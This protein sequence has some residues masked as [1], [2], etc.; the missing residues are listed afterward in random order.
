[1]FV[2]IFVSTVT[3]TAQILSQEASGSSSAVMSDSRSALSGGI[4]NAGTLDYSYVTHG[5]PNDASICVFQ[6]IYCSWIVYIGELKILV[7]NLDIYCLRTSSLDRLHAMH[8]TTRCDQLWS[9]SICFLFDSS[10]L[11]PPLP[12]V[13]HHLD[14]STPTLY[15]ESRLEWMD[16]PITQWNSASFQSLLCYVFVSAVMNSERLI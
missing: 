12:P 8:L 7:L 16:W 13:S 9:S 1:M 6:S 4:S 10:L 3:D 5:R 2:F 15:T 11:P 14:H